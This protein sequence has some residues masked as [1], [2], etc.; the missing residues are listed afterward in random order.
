MLEKIHLHHSSPFFVMLKNNGTYIWMSS[1]GMSRDKLGIFITT[2]F[3][4]NFRHHP[5]LPIIIEEI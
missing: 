5:T 3:H 1:E 2:A 4:G